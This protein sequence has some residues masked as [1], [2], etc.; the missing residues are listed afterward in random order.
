M[1]FRKCSELLQCSC[2]L[3][4]VGRTMWAFSTHLGER[5]W[6]IKRAFKNH[7]VSLHFARVHNKDLSGTTFLAIDTLSLPWRGIN[8]VVKY[9]DWK[10]NGS[11]IW[12]PIHH[13]AW[14]SIGTWMHLSKMHNHFFKSTFMPCTSCI[15]GLDWQGFFWVK[16]LLLLNFCYDVKNIFIVWLLYSRYVL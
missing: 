5:V 10:Q 4:Y 14:M 16:N 15:L 1:L 6:N 12:D 3:W 13:M 9:P 11:L 2:G 7:S 8:I